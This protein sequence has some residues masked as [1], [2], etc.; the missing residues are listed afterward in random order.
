MTISV[1]TL[2]EE[3]DATSVDPPQRR[4]FRETQIVRCIGLSGLACFDVPQRRV[5]QPGNSGPHTR[6]NPLRSTLPSSPHFPVRHEPP[7]RLSVGGRDLLMGRIQRLLLIKIRSMRVLFFKEWPLEFPRVLVIGA[8]D[9]R[10]R[11][12]CQPG[13]RHD[14]LWASPAFSITSETDHVS[15]PSPW[16]R[17]CVRLRRF[18]PRHLPWGVLTPH[19]RRNRLRVSHRSF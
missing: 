8:P 18:A 7:H 4:P 11:D 10:S 17:E 1:G 6:T 2:T 15:Y 12:V 3:S 14:I 19:P 5:R 13:F 16:F 9:F